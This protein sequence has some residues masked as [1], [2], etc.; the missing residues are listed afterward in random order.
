M[1]VSLASFIPLHLPVPS[2][3]STATYNARLLSMNT[4]FTVLILEPLTPE[5][6]VVS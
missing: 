6:R 4:V 3:N 2:D 1:H 5:P